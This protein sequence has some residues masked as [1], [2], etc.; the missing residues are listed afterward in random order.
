[1]LLQQVLGNGQGTRLDM[2]FISF[3]V[4]GKAAVGHVHKALLGQLR[5]QC[6]EYAQAPNAAVKHA[7]GQA[8]VWCVGWLRA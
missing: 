1:M 3:T 5:V 7:N 2:G 4:G 8:G 6:F